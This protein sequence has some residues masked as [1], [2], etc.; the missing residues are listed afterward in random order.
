MRIIQLNKRAFIFS[1]QP[2]DL[3]NGITSN[4]LDAPKNALL[5]AQGKII[6]I[7]DQK[8]IDAD[9]TMLVIDNIAA[10]TCRAMFQKFAAFTKT[11]WLESDAAIYYDL[12]ADIKAQEGFTLL[13]QPQGQLIVGGQFETTITDEAFTQFRLDHHIPLHG[14]DF[15]DEM[16]LN[17]FPENY[18]SYTKG[19]FIGQ[20]VIA[21]VHNLSKPPRKL[22]VR[23]TDDCNETEKNQLTSITPDKTNRPRGFLFTHNK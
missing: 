7:A 23:H 9:T 2:T 11:K 12:D 19:C 17:V 10:K 16:L 21:R 6:A 22:V 4:T 13:P 14:Q 5:T 1:P 20:E 18:A 15:T 3:L 8:Q